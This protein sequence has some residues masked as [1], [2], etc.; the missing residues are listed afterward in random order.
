M[1]DSVNKLKVFTLSALGL[2]LLCTLLFT[3]SMFVSFDA[4]VGYF[5]KSPI[6]VIQKAIAAVSVI[7]FASI[8][9]FIPKST[10][11]CDGFEGDRST[12]FSSLLCGLVFIG[13][14]IITF[15][16]T[17]NS[18]ANLSSTQRSLF[19]IITASGIIASIYFISDALT[20][21]KKNVGIKVATA[22]LVIVNLLC[23]VIFEH[24]DLFVP[25]NAPRKTLLFLSFV[26]AS[27]FI[28]QELR[29]KVGIYQPRAYVFAGSAT[30]LLCS[31]MS[32]PSLI[33]HYAGVFKDSSFLVYYLIG[34]ALAI[35]TSARL[36]S[37][38]MYVDKNT[39]EE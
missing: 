33:A 29:F 10:L 8:M 18:A 13:G 4:D 37:Y 36:I 24:L 22:I 31:V 30:A 11:P 14:M 21:Y 39:S 1:K 20:P 2:T 15:L 7:F 35:Y 34:L 32:I 25:I 12:V 3:I 16:S 9:F 6:T 38:T 19:M 23:S 5:A 28:I 27:V 26:S 17:Y